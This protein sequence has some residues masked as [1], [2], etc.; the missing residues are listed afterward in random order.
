MPANIS[1]SVTEEHPGALPNWPVAIACRNECAYYKEDAGKILLGCVRTPKLSLG[2]GWQ[3]Q[4]TS[5]FANWPEDF[6][7]ISQ[8][9]LEA[10]CQLECLILAEAGIH[11]LF[12]MALK[13]LPPMNRYY[14]GEH[15]R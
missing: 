14:L 13:V 9:I 3:F 4:R 11:D 10:A 15:Q 7:T 5:G 2:A 1:T 8:P 6:E 12:L